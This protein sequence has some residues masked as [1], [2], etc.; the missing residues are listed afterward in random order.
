MLL[1]V[2]RAQ[3]QRTHFRNGKRLWRVLAV[4]P[5]DR[6]PGPSA[7]EIRTLWHTHTVAINFVA[8]CR[9][10]GRVRM[11][12]RIRRQRLSVALRLLNAAPNHK[13]GE[14][15]D[16]QEDEEQHD[17]DK[18]EQDDVSFLLLLIIDDGDELHGARVTEG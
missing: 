10:K 13:G 7:C 1:R 9:G 2:L 5:R 14:E 3:V 15:D 16:A 4:C 8:V 12:Q 17:A 6:L 18:D 11:V